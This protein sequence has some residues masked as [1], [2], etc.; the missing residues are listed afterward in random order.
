MAGSSPV[1]GTE[2]TLSVDTVCVAAGLKP[3]IGLASQL[4]CAVAH[5]QELGGIVPIHDPNMESTSLGVFVAGDISGVGEAST[6]MDEGRLAGIAVAERL[7]FVEEGELEAESARIHHRLEALR[8]GPFG[9]RVRDGKQR[10]HALYF[11]NC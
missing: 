7:G 10:I 2:S 1:P 8:S 4:G 6:A 3:R 9:K 11:E 5:I